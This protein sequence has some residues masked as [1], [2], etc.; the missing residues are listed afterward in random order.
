MDKSLSGILID[1]F[2]FLKDA[3]DWSCDDGWFG[4]IL[5]LSLT[6]QSYLDNHPEIAKD[7]KVAQIKEKF[8]GLRFYTN[9]I[10]EH[11]RSFIDSAYRRS[12]ATCEV[13]GK[14]GETYNFACTK[15]LCKKHYK[16]FYLKAKTVHMNNRRYN[17]VSK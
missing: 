10:D 6:I 1:S 7:F 9:S 4:I 17:E 11:I 5:D 14:K 2:P 15:T 13:C 3:S 8:G 12:L 16:I